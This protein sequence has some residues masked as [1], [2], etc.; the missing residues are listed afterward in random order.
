M[1]DENYQHR[2]QIAAFPLATFHPYR[3]M[4]EVKTA[5][6]LFALTKTRIPKL[7]C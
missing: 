2:T 6:L 3:E 1:F 4:N 5:S 7:R